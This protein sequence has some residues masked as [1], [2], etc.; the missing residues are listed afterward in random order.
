MTMRLHSNVL[1]TAASLS[2]AALLGIAGLAGAQTAP[3]AA[4][5]AKP[6]AAPATAPAGG[7]REITW[8]ALMPADW[9]PMKGMKSANFG[10]FS[11]ADPR[12][13]AMLKELRETWDN[14]PINPA[15]NGATVK[16]P[17]Y[18]VPL[19]ESKAGLTEFLLVPYFGACVHS[20][21]PPANQIIHVQRKTPVKGFQSMDAVWVVGTLKTTRSDTFMGVSGYQLEATA[22][23]AYRSGG[24]AGPDGKTR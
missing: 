23:E 14:A 19:E 3:K 21:P 20:P 7:V 22:V 13:A 2:A 4:P 8:D 1:R 6:A 10:M 11:D 16:I 18:V 15:M 9:D 12:A 5:V 24:G 17:G